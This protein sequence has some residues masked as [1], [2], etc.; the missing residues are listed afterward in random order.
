LVSKLERL[1]FLDTRLKTLAA[2]LRG[3]HNK[4]PERGS[5]ELNQVGE[6]VN[7]VH[8]LANRDGVL[9]RLKSGEPL[10]FEAAQQADAQLVNAG[11]ASRPRRQATP[12]TAEQRQYT[13]ARR[14]RKGTG[15]QNQLQF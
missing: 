6:F 5:V 7:A 11:T 2:G 8:F 4:F 15:L 9:E 1:S 3:V 13:G 14:S 12:S 10:L